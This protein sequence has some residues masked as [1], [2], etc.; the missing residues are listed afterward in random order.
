MHSLLNTT[1]ARKTN[2]EGD[3]EQIS[4]VFLFKR[5]LLFIILKKELGYNCY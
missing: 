1:F 3:D 2:N 4:V 5:N